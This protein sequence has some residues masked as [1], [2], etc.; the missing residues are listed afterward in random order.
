MS[1]IESDKQWLQISPRNLKKLA[2][3]FQVDKC[4]LSISASRD[5]PPL[6]SKSTTALTKPRSMFKDQLSVASI[7]AVTVE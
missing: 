1:K 3:S 7:N 2:Q 5:T 4:L 6:R